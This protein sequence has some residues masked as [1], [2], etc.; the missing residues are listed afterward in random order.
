VPE[1]VTLT[2]TNTVA[3]TVPVSVNF[4]PT[5]SYANG[6]YTSVTVCV[7]G[8]T[9]NCTTIPNV[10]VDTGS[11]GLRLLSSGA[12]GVTT[13][14]GSLGLPGITDPTTSLPIYECVQ[15][16]DLS[17]TWGPMQMATVQVGGETASQ[18]PTASGGTANAGIPIQV[19]TS[20]TQ[21]PQDVLYNGTEYANPCTYNSDGTATGGADDDTVANLGSNGILGVGLFPQDCGLDCTTLANATGQYVAYGASNGTADVEPTAL[22]DQAW[23]PVAAFPVDN[24]GVWLS[25][26]SIPAAGQA[27][28]AGTL[29]F[30]IGTETNNAIPSGANV[31]EIDDYGNFASATYNGVT[32]N[33]TNSGG[34]FIDSGSNALY[35]SDETTL[36]TTDCSGEEAGFYCP[37]STL[38][39]SLG[40]EGTN[41]TSPTTVSLPIANAVDLFSANTSYAAFNDLAG[42]SCTPTTTSPCTSATDMWDLGLPFFFGQTN[43]IFVGIYGTNTTY[44]NGY[45]AF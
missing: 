9:T 39:L 23:N 13:Q 14:V 8:S 16:G 12:A 42:P 28:V 4:G 10:L 29:T 45:W 3:N 24:N 2:G 6:I 19:I 22:A 37:T 33:S 32:Y 35:V 18:V 11:V 40:L 26:P 7:P 34:S 21:P 5:G 25:L 17:Y 38:N 30:G 44:P 41:S 20:A 31:Y 43:G 1:N 15:Y 36:D 27:T